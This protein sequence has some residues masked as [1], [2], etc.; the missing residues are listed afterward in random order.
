[1]APV[2]SARRAPSR[3]EGRGLWNG[4][5]WRTAG[6]ADL[7]YHERSGA[8]RP[9]VQARVLYDDRFLHL[10]FRVQQ[11]RGVKAVAQNYQEMVCRD[12][13]VEFFVKPHPDRGYFNF[14]V[15]AGGCLLLHYTLG[16]G[17]PDSGI[18]VPEELLQG[19]PIHH[20][21]PRHIDPELDGPCDWTIEYAVPLSLFEHYTGPLGPLAGQTW[22]CNFFKCADRTSRPHWALWSPISDR[23]SFH[24]T[25][26]FGKLVFAP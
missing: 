1:M 10:L 9:A 2:Y 8:H 17:D 21:L 4:P 22:R 11:D 6:T 13:C 24:Q 14:E 5:V 26:C 19:M 18:N 23:F 25:A 15:N 3:P 7:V 16:E 12:S 20:S